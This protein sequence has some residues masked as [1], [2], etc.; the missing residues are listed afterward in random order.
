MS[1]STEFVF[2]E[3]VGN[4]VDDTFNI[5]F[6]LIGSEFGVI[7]AFLYQMG[8]AMGDPLEIIVEQTAPVKDGV[9]TY[10]YTILSGPTRAVTNNPIPIGYK[11]IFYRDTGTISPVTYTD[12][13][14]PYS[15]VTRDLDRLYQLVQES[16]LALNHYNLTELFESPDKAGT[17]FYELVRTIISSIPGAVSAG[18]LEADIIVTGV[19]QGRYNSGDVILAGTSFEEIL[20]DMLTLDTPPVFTLA[21]SGAKLVE[22]GTVLTPTLTGVYVAN[23]AGP[24]NNYELR[25]E[26]SPVYVGPVPAAYPDGPFTII[27]QSISYQAT[28]DYDA[29]LLPLGSIVSNTITYTG[30]RAAFYQIGGDIVN[31]RSNTLKLVGVT[32]G[33]KLITTGDNASLT[34]VFA[35]PSTLGAPTSLFFSN[36]GGNFDVTTDL[37]RETDQSVNDASGANPI[38]YRVYSYTALIPIESADTLTFTI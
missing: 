2:S 29:N 35:Y 8:D 17:K 7:K 1:N 10:D 16:K 24:A 31:I 32:G 6:D 21:G 28:L 33:S 30:A 23:D 15:T 38:T 37:V 34:C 22:S 27:D 5:S 14:F 3:Y 20:R 18:G 9:G 13:R 12:Y 25:K 26:G 19:S 11:I 4:D 36:T